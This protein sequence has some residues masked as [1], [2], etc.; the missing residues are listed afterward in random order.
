MGN[1]VSKNEVA[2]NSDFDNATTKSSGSKKTAFEILMFLMLGAIICLILSYAGRDPFSWIS[3]III[4]I[5]FLGLFFLKG[6]DTAKEYESLIGFFVTL[7]T[8]LVAIYIGISISDSQKVK[9][10][11]NRLI[12]VLNAS[13]T[14]MDDCRHVLRV[15]KTGLHWKRHPLTQHFISYIGRKTLLTFL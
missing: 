11:Q 2:S 13:K 15:Q 8:T 7:L 6:T 4:I 10:D 5:L 3:I 1:K 14:E 12:S 9:A